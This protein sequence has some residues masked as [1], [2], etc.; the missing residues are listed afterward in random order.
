MTP[1][2]L[3]DIILSDD[4]LDLEKNEIVDEEDA[5]KSSKD[6][7]KDCLLSRKTIVRVTL[8]LFVAGSVAAAVMMLPVDV[9]I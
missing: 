4:E 8:L 1:V 2:S 9:R 6:V 5:K 7:L 3:E